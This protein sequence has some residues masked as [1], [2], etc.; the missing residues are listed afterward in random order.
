MNWSRGWKRF[1]D[2]CLIFALTFLLPVVIFCVLLLT[3]TYLYFR[4]DCTTEV[5]NEIADPSGLR[6]EISETDCDGIAKWGTESVFVSD[7]NGRDKVE[8]FQFAPDSYRDPMPEIV[9]IP[10]EKKI[11]IALASLEEVNSQ[12]HHWR[13]M[14]IEYHLGYISFPRPEAET[15]KD[16]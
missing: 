3:L 15:A 9:V 1:K 8:L 12:K 13:E 4:P 2:I 7:Q 10:N 14:T 16:R 5:R 11:S 6:F